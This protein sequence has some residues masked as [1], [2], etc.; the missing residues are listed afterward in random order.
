MD[1]NKI[2]ESIADVIDQKPS[3]TMWFVF[4]DGEK[5]D[6][7]LANIVSTEKNQKSD[8]MQISKV[9]IDKLKDMCNTADTM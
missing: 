3:F 1:L 2:M 6:I 5:I 4:K 7:R 8:Q 9:F